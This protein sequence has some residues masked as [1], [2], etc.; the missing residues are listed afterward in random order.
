MT[1]A[2]LYLSGSVQRW[3]MNPA[4]AWAG[5]TDADHQGRCVLLLL[6][7]HSDPSVALIRA[8]A[9]HDVGELGA[10]D[11][12][13]DLK[14][15]EPDL[16]ARHAAFET[17][18]REALCGPDPELSHVDACWLKLIDRLEATCWCLT[19]NPR[20]YERSS[21]GWLAAEPVLLADADRLGC[22]DAVHG[23]L[24]D[25]KGGRW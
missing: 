8:V 22:R 25:L 17:A 23:L 1:L 7:L 21:S 18:E 15:R 11:L 5:Q 24:H 13:Y 19:N 16:A 9:T 20:E 6:A 10:G 4:M 14:R 2:R 12:S 3:H